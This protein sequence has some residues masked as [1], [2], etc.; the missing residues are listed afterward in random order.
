MV[1]DSSARLLGGNMLDDANVINQRDPSGALLVAAEQ[2]KQASFEANIWNDEHDDRQIFNVV[3]TG[4]GGSALAAGILKSWLKSDIEVPFEVV[5]SYT[6]PA[7]VGPNTLVIASS[8]SGN[9]EETIGCL[10]QAEVKGA[11]LAIIASSG[12]LIDDAAG[13]KIAHVA[14]PTDMQPRMA[15]IYNLR[16]LA[17]LLVNFDIIQQDRLD[18]IASVSDWLRSETSLWVSDVPTERNY[19]K[20]LAL[21]AVGK[22]AIFYGGELTSPIAYKWKIGWNENSKNLA[23]WNELPEFNHN[24]F[25]GWTSHPVEKPFAVFDIISNL[26]HPQIL[27]RFE[28]SDKLLSGKRPKATEIKLAGNSAIQQLLWGS[29]LADFVSIYTAILNGVDPTPVPLIERLKDELK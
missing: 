11:Q 10:E 19:A 23:F 21:S 27:K 22:S 8:Y 16:A 2:Y 9:T 15:V 14:L 26:E 4:M 25:I 3:V 7:Y 24:E 28:I 5:R 17:A 20:Q 13:F 29:I 1:I 12:K 18:E 6:L